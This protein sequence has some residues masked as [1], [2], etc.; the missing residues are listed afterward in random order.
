MSEKDFLDKYLW[1][2]SDRLDRTFTHPLPEIEGLQK[3]G[4]FIVQCE[5]EDTFSTNIMAKYES[6]VEAIRL[7]EVY[8]CT[9]NIVTGTFVRL[10]GTMS[11]VK[12]GYPFL[13][14]DASIRNVNMVTGEREDI[15]TRIAIHL[16]QADSEQRQI[17]FPHLSEQAKD[18]G[19]AYRDMS[20]DQ[21]PDFWGTIWLGEANGVNLDMIHKVRDYA[22]SSYKGI[23][24]KTE[25]KAPF[26][27]SPFQ[28]QMI[29]NVSGL[30]HETFR[31]MGL[32]VPVESQAA[33]F[34]VQI[35][36]I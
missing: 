15:A 3:C 35:S 6:A 21:L 23:M 17:F 24:E 20:V 28:K 34:S 25:R 14:L 19:I 9:Q 33:F 1:P 8:K 16:P 18:G 27:Y 10:V 4:D 26:D 7:V 36:G 29:F 5:H 32:S 12:Q 13:L 31:K 2:S 22:W 30:E 11:V